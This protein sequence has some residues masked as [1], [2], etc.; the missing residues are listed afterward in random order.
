MEKEKIAE[1]CHSVNKAYC[2]SIDDNSQLD[3]KD[4]PEWQKTSAINGVEFHL[5]STN[6]KPEDSHNSWLEE[7]R[8]DGWKYGKVK[9]AEK[10]EHPCFVPYDQ[11]PKEQKAKDYIFKAICDFF[12]DRL[13]DWWA[14]RIDKELLNK[15]CGKAASTFSNTPTIK[16]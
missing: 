7:K 1:L 12:K 14:E 5:E 9:D 16:E 15:L 3:W 8:L 13:T 10:K 11:L 4:A 6:T 2:Q